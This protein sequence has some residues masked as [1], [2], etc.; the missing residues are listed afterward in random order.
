LCFINTEYKSQ[1]TLLEK[2]VYN[3]ASPEVASLMKYSDFSELDY[4]GK[5][6]ISIPI[7]NIN[8][9]KVKIPIDLSYNT[10]GN[11]VA[12][13]ATSVG[14]GWD[15][16]AGGNLTIK[17][18]D[19]NDLTETYAYYT[20][21][22][23][24]PE[25]SLSWHRQSK[26]FLCTTWPDQL[27]YSN[28]NGQ[29]LC[30]STRIEWNDD[31][32]VDAAPDFYYINA[33]GF[34][35][36]FYLT[37]INDTQFKAHF[38]N[39]TNAKLNNNLILTIKP[40]CGGFESTFWG[41]SGK[42]SVF[43]QIDKF[44]IVGE[45]GYIY[46][47]NDYE[48][49][50]ITEYP[51]DFLSH[52]SY[53]V[54]N[55]Y[56]S[57]MKDP[58]SGREVKFEYETYVNNYEHPS[59]NTIEDVDFGNYNVA[60]NYSLGSNSSIYETPPLI[61]NKFTTS[62]FAIKRLKKL[63]TDQETI[64]FTYAFNRIDYP[65]NG[66]SNIK[67]KSKG[68]DIIK[69]AD[70]TYSYFDSSG[71]TAGNYECKRLRLDKIEDS[72]LGSYNFSYD[73][74]NFPARNSSKVDFL[75]YYNNNSSNITFSKTDFH[76][77]DLNYFPKAKTYFYPDLATDNILPFKLINK[78]PYF[79]PSGIDKT[80]SSISKLG[81]LQRI[82]Y[83]TGGALELN[84]ENDDF[85]FEGEKYI[86]GSTRINSMK[87]YDSQNSI[88]KEIK[89]KYLNTNNKSSGQINFI[90]TPS[91]V[92]RTYVSSGIGFNTGAIV[93]YSRIV[94]EVT[95]KGYIEK[96][97]SNF[98][99]Y[100]DKFMEPDTNFTDQGVKNLLKF[101]KFPS[102][103]VQSFDG[104]RG[105]LLSA[106]YYKEG[107]TT[108]IKKET[109]TYDYHVKDSIK[110]QKAFSSY[111]N[112][113]Y[114][115]SGTYTS[116]NYLLRYFNNTSSNSK[117]EFLT[118]GSI[119]EENFFSYDDSR[120][121]YKKSVSNGD[122]MEEYYRNAKDK[123]IQKLIDVNIFDKY[124]EVE[125]KK[126]GKTLTK[127]EAKYENP[128]TIFP[129]SEL[130][131]D[132][133]T[134]LM[135]PEVIYDQY[136]NQ[137]NLQQFTTRNGVSTTIIWG[138]NQ[139]QPIAKIEGA[140][141][142]DVSQTLV[143]NIVNASNDDNVPPQGVSKNQ[144][145][146]NLLLVLNAFRNDASLNSYK[147]TTYTYDP[148]IGV[149]TITPSSGV[150]ENYIYDTANRL[151]KIVDANS[152]IIK[153]YKYNY[154]PT[155]YYN[156]ERSGNFAK[157]CGSSGTGTSFTYI[158]PANKYTS[159]ISQ[160]DADQKAVDEI[161]ANGQNAANNN[162]NGTCT[163]INCTV[164]KGSQINQFNYGSISVSNP[165]TYRIQ[166]GFLYETNNQYWNQGG[167]IIGKIN[168]TCIPNGIRTS[169]TYSNGIWNLA[170][171]TNGYIKATISSASPSLVNNTNV[172]LDFTFS[173]N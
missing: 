84:Y 22:T 116:S 86:L 162:P 79:E 119:K 8:F 114:N 12:D 153:E 7:Y 81:L 48:I 152:N 71:C 83:P 135:E 103:Y 111:I 15:L 59:L 40:T 172:A 144:T 25:Q 127:Q 117:E 133:K 41:N 67:V 42:A 23:F 109:Y 164:V 70:F 17:V 29:Q 85:I 38:F 37:R 128:S 94:E 112:F 14:L 46:T 69:Q 122:I 18:N 78:Q 145:E 39:S 34:N 170:I 140:K 24:E 90:T 102:S 121:T 4:I 139:T 74:N 53:Q 47:F 16:N 150:R 100:P 110:V 76:P 44:E 120:L 124:V 98:S 32:M 9:G 58:V 20:T 19:Q 113:G 156:S 104:R 45:N 77:Y 27:F 65:G 30:I 99:D 158:V 138:Y 31:G 43:Y 148:L 126:N 92:A 72:S 97:Y 61:Y 36:K 73:I 173:I 107:Q 168:G 141:L 11:K 125:K 91:N 10:K 146:Q 101:L 87:L 89:Y 6:N 151:E 115:N 13:I 60:T 63:I 159:T 21:S 82:V 55:W 52:D 28:I 132:L 106:N 130:A 26:G 171:D 50:K 75:G 137:G 154:A 157:Y 142:S 118:G 167:T 136:D 129:S 131:Y 1:Q 108:P 149:T 105:K 95:G 64:E 160:S 163:T 49:G 96:N 66:L 51:Q 169:S 57:K 5:T 35:D 161:A 68:G 54:N 80:P 143:N 93:G 166:I 2:Q 155:K 33:P 147:I 165:T 88:S 62:Q 3:V 123:S 56:L 134:N